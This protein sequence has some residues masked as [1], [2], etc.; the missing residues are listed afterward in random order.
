MSNQ[1]SHVVVVGAGIGGL[2]A[3][4]DL[5]ASGL[6]VTL[7]ERH[8]TPGGKMREHRVGDQR[9]DAGPTVFTMRWV[10]EELFIRAGTRLAERVQARQ[11]GV[12]AR[13][14]WVDGSRLDLYADL[15]RS[16]AAISEFAGTAE[17]AAYR[18][19]ARESQQMFE[20]LDHTFM[21]VERPSPT[22]LTRA[23]GLG[24][25]PRLYATKPFATMWRELGKIFK[26]P[27]LRQLFGRY[28]TYCG[29]SPFDAPATLMLIAHAERTGVW[30][31]EG[32]MQRL[33]EAM[34]DLAG[35][36]GVELRYGADV[37]RLDTERNRVRAV[38]LGD[39]ERIDAD[40]VVFNGDVAALNNGLLG[41]TVRRATPA[42]ADEPRSL[43]A[44]TWSLDARTAGFPLHYHNVFFGTDYP[45]EFSSIFARQRVTAEPTVYVC[46]K[47]RMDDTVPA[48]HEPLLLLINAP[49]RP[50]SDDELAAIETRTFAFLQR[51][52]LEIDIDGAASQRTSPNDF[53]R[54]F[55]GSDGAIYGW[56]THGWSG[57][58]KRHGCRAELPGLYLAGGSVH[59]GPGVPMVALSGRLAAAAVR[60]DLGLG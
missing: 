43:S 20:T 27:R 3:A 40:A 13:H 7:L 55:P 21:R 23:L 41:D 59:P 39:G 14:A 30:L 25:L 24:G 12:L 18:R 46:A 53:D 22:G 31:V 54:L 58:F 56:P 17:A 2:A 19:F 42:R 8:A 51:H 16:A 29:S 15:D 34:A 60:T 28:A 6:R 49:P 35:E 57:S 9:V 36:L 45:D 32:G 37:A 47:S 5:A 10:F 38:R 48:D 33:A 1:S 4:I 50:F 11:A 44:I 52:G 26:D